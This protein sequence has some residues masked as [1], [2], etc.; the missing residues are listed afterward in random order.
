MRIKRQVDWLC[1]NAR[2]VMGLPVTKTAVTVDD[3]GLGAAVTPQET[4]DMVYDVLLTF[5]QWNTLSV[6]PVG[7][8][9]QVL[10]LISARPTGYWITTQGAQITEGAFTGTSVTLTIQEAAAWIPVARALLDD[11]PADFAGYILRQLSESVANRLDHACFNAAGAAD[12]TDGG[13]T[14]IAR[15]GTAATAT[16]GN[17]TVATLDLEDFVR[18]LTTVT[19]GVLSRPAKWWMHPTILAKVVQ[20]RDGNGRPI[21]QTALEAPAPGA[22]GSIL[23]YP[24]V[25][26]GA[27]PSTDSTG[28][29]VACFGDPEGGAV[30]IRKSFDLSSSDDFQFDYHRR[31]FKV[32][33]RAGFVIRLA[34]AFARLVTA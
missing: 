5:G 4:N 8:A 25:V 28:Q 1:N 10:P 29:P 26:A 16:A 12:S 24:V 20:I 18:C 6:V 3:S 7:S 2:R 27:M 15:G 32:V 22:I 17:T 11:A 23:G 9:T 33:V 30:G 34:T 13:Y 14:G 21:F 31:A 19:A